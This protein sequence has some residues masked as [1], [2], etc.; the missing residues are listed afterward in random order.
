MVYLV[1]CASY[2]LKE[3]SHD[4]RHMDLSKQKNEKVVWRMKR[5]NGGLPG[6]PRAA[7]S[8]ATDLYISINNKL[9]VF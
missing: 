9:M 3:S 4:A 2:P 6:S 1:K 8:S 7:V 5:G